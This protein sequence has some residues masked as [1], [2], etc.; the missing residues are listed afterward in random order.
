MGIIGRKHSFDFSWP[1][2]T[3]AFGKIRTFNFI[4]WVSSSLQG[5][6]FTPVYLRLASSEA[7]FLENGN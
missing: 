3:F 2:V 1:V 6:Q 4:D 7:H 5:I